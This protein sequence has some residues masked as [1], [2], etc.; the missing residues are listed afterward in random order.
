[1]ITQAKHNDSGFSV[2]YEDGSVLSVPNAEGNRHYQEL[3]QWV[4]EGNVILPQYTSEELNR[5]ALEERIAEL[6]QLLNDSDYK[7]LPDYDKTTDAIKVQR[8]DWREE[9]RELESVIA[10]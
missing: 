10:R 2:T 6:Q 9:I 8:Q 1:M 4:A 3:M 5:Q 7:V